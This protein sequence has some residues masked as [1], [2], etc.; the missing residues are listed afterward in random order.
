[1]KTFLLAATVAAGLLCS[2]NTADAQLLRRNRVYYS[3]D[4]YPAYSYYGYP[5]YSS[6]YYPSPSY[7]YI[8]PSYSSGVVT[9]SG[10]SSG[11]IPSSGT[12]YEPRYSYPYV[13]YPG[14]L[15]YPSYY[16]PSGSDWAWRGWRW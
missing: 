7:T 5:T 10:Y 1:M 8:T 6:S 14:T 4:Y 15:A 9:T 11:V 12:Y 2:A 3:S 13:G 16:Y